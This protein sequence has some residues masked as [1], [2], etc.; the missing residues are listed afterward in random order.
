MIEF[1]HWEVD[2]SISRPRAM[3]EDEWRSRLDDLV[4]AW[5]RLNDAPTDVIELT[6]LER[7]VAGELRWP[8]LHADSVPYAATFQGCE[9][10]PPNFKIDAQRRNLTFEDP[11][12]PRWNVPL[13]GSALIVVGSAL[14]LAAGGAPWWSVAM[15]SFAALVVAAE[16]RPVEKREEDQQ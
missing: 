11:R 15:T 13:I 14:Q 2:M 9:S 8:N 10:L 6:G 4:A 1:E 5:A 16:S 7:D 3:D 12:E